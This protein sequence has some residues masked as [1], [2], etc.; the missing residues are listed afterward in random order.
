MGMV[1]DGHC[2]NC[3]VAYWKI[4]HIQTEAIRYLVVAVGLDCKDCSAVTRNQSEASPDSDAWYGS[5]GDW[6]PLEPLARTYYPECYRLS[7]E[8]E[9]CVLLVWEAHRRRLT[10]SDRQQQMMVV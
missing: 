7:V 8:A 6:T 4:D 1:D 2:S 3:S 9:S 10:V 5:D